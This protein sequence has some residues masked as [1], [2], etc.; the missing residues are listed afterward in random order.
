MIANLPA[1][2]GQSLTLEYTPSSRWSDEKD[3]T[4]TYVMITNVTFNTHQKD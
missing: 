2:F 1:T 4:V 3:T